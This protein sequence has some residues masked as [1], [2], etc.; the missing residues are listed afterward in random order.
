MIGWLI[1]DNEGYERN[2]WF[3]D[4]LIE[5]ALKFNLNI[6]LKIIENDFNYQIDFPTFA[7]IRTINPRLTKFL[8]DNGV[9]T[10]NNYN[11]SLIANDKWKTYEFCKKLNIETMKTYPLKDYISLK[12]L[13]YPFVIKSVD[14]HGGKEVF[15]VK[16]SLYLNN[17]LNKINVNRYIA[18]DF[19]SNPGIDMRVYL[20]NGEIL[21][22]MLRENN[23][24]FK[25]N[26]TLGGS[27]RVTQETKEQKEI[28]TKIQ[29]ALKS[30]LIGIDFI[31]NNN[32]WVL[33]EIEDVVGTRMIYK[34]TNIDIIELYLKHISTKVNIK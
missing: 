7:I 8:E 3:A 30:D 12:N 9:T 20:L 33:N 21:A 31:Y 4:N 1:Y 13:K 10:F 34:L 27:A 32:K 2:K 5:K 29:N 18:Q 16:D 14:G 22:S 17:L 26:F 19:C 15:L 25:S 6:K 11:T 23:K 28:I 24:D